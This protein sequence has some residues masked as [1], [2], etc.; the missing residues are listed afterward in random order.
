MAQSIV[1]VATDV[2]DDG[3]VVVSCHAGPAALLT[4][5]CNAAVLGL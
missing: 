2:V 4:V 1:R 5:S 3:P